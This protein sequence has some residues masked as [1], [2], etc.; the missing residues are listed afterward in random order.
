MRFPIAD[1]TQ[2]AD[3]V[4]VAGFGL[5]GGGEHPIEGPREQW[6]GFL[7]SLS[8]QRLTGV[9]LAAAESGS[10]AL[11]EGQLEDLI[12][13]QGQAMRWALTIE[14]KL[15]TLAERFTD[16]GVEVV[17]L[18]GPTMAHTVYPDPSWRPF[19]DLDLLVRTTDWRRALDV[20]IDLGFERRLP[21]PRPGFDERFGKAAVHTNGDGV[22]I[23][24]HRTLVVGPFGLWARPDELFR[25]AVRFELGGRT[26]RRLDDTALLLH[27]CMHATLGW[28]P[29]LLW[30]LRD[31]AQV[32]WSGRVDWNELADLA[33]RWRL[34]AVVRHALLTASETIEVSLPTEA[35]PWISTEPP[36]REVRALES[37]VTEH[38]GRGGTEL[39]MFRA[40]PG[41]AG[42]F[43]YA[44][45]L[46]FPGRA[47]LAAR[48]RG[49]FARLLVPVRWLTGRRG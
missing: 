39:A 32:A 48:G 41:L 31:V 16:A 29:P 15:L 7:S 21:E 44:R 40:I 10:L 22:E 37:Y 28:H 36:R 19:G 6:P 34:R 13:Q 49:P 26:L 3:L 42:K 25:R 20:L 1:T 17:A 14:R 30:T 18:K 2:A 23:D 5:P 9:A 43:T 38:R 45:M 33:Q 12:A 27:A 46:L 47:F 8:S 35:G 11:D 4:R 24:L